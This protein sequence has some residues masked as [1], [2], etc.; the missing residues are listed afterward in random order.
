MHACATTHAH[1]PLAFWFALPLYMAVGVILWRGFPALRDIF[2]EAGYVGGMIVFAV[3]WPF[4]LVYF[5][6]IMTIA[7]VFV[8]LEKV[9]QFFR[10]K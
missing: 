8:L 10:H 4:M 3:L 9:F 5:A 1:L 2:G 7:S 6:W